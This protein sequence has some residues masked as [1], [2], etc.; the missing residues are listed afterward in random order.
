MVM[1]MGITLSLDEDL[2]LE[3]AYVYVKKKLRRMM[4]TVAVMPTL[5]TTMFCTLLLCNL[6]G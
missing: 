5:R 2:D 6:S 4:H 1:G 3:I